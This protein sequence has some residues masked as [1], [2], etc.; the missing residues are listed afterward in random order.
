MV[1][2]LIERLGVVAE[3]HHICPALRVLGR[4]LRFFERL[5]RRALREAL[6]LAVVLIL[7]LRL[8]LIL[9]LRR[10]GFLHVLVP[11]LLR[12]RRTI[13]LIIRV[14]RDMVIS[15]DGATGFRTSANRKRLRVSHGVG[16]FCRFHLKITAARECDRT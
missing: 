4:V 14:V 5:T 3:L 12:Q 10:I 9:T 13:L 16:I 7:M 6:E 8:L 2:D 11:S 1:Q 15:P